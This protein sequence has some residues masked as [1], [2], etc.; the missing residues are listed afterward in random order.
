MLCRLDLCWT[1]T[2][3]CQIFTV[4]SLPM[5]S[6]SRPIQSI[7]P[8]TSRPVLSHIRG[9]QTSLSFKRSAANPYVTTNIHPKLTYSQSKSSLRQKRRV[10]A[11]DTASLKKGSLT[12]AFICVSIANSAQPRSSGLKVNFLGKAAMRRCILH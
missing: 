7:R 9:L 6:A 2:G 5:P 3:L 8:A 4:D 12:A 10:P 11:H 1:F